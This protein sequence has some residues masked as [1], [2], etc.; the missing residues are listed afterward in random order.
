MKIWEKVVSATSRSNSALIC[1]RA[2]ECLVACVCKT[3]E[4]APCVQLS[5]VYAEKI[6]LCDQLETIADSLPYRV[7]RLDCIRVAS[8]LLPLLRES[9]RYEEEVLFPVFERHAD[10]H[11]GRRSTVLRLKSEHLYDEGAAEEICER[12][13]WIGRGGEIDNPEALGFMLRAFFDT[14]RR[15]IA[16]EREFVLP[17]A[18][19]ESLRNA[20]GNA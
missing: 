11:P 8:R 4:Q 6:Q 7:D 13:M 15:H 14:V 1:F 3:G 2:D 5:L 12:L 18:I 19:L 10:V 20:K 17:E 9:H 16:F